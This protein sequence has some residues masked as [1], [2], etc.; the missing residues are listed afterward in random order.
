MKKCLIT[1]VTGQ[2]GSYLAEESLHKGYSVI[3]LNRRTSLN[4]C[5]RIHHI[6]NDDNF[7]LVEGDVIDIHSISG[8]IQSYQPHY[9]INCAAQSH[10]H[11]SFKQPKYTFDVNTIGVLNILESLKKYSPQTKMVQF[12]TSE[13]FG[14]Q[15]STDNIGN[16]Y[17]DENTVLS[18]QS[19]YAV[20]KVAA[21]HLCNLYRKAYDVKV[22]C[23]IM[24]NAESPRRGENFVTRKITKYVAKLWQD[25]QNAEGILVE[26]PRLQLGNLDAKRDWGYV[27]DYCHAI[28]CM[29]QSEKSDNYVI[30]T[31]E[32]HSIREFLDL[33]FRYIGINDWTPYVEINP[34]FYR[35]AE[36]E[37]LKG[38]SMKA[39]RE[40]NWKPTIKFPELVE[41]MMRAEINGI[42]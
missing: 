29:L 16:K 4:N 26:Y 10:V 1:G 9:L 37:F 32:T 13:M 38:K 24:F 8:V 31:E 35:P 3:G 11:S 34:K 17:Q 41:L 42:S 21:H 33:A 23:I 7:T 28:F 2:V 40:L 12:S 30:C 19:P 15:Y 14:D 27:V 5:G 36:V 18:P 22:S 6:L 20:A 25:L 39:Q